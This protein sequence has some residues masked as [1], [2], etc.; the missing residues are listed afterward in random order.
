MRLIALTQ[1]YS[2]MVDDEDFDWLSQWKWH[3][4]VKK[5]TVYA[6]RN[7]RCEDGKCKTILMHREIL[8]LLDIKIHGE[9]ADGNGLNNTRGNIRPSTHSQNMMNRDSHANSSSVFKGVSW[10]KDR[11]KW[12]SSIKVNG[13]NKHLGFFENE[14]DAA[15]NYNHFAKKLHREYAR[16]NKV[17]PMFPDKEWKPPVLRMGNKSGFRGVSFNKDSGKWAASISN[18][19]VKKH[20]GYF[21]DPIDA[22]KAYD[23]AAKELHGENARL[24]FPNKNKIHSNANI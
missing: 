4:K 15:R 9:H 21:K 23:T 17:E 16:F 11:N 20:I 12:V 8:G 19:G 1:G 18:N 22:A 3:S 6:K 10:R 24:N 7:H 2:A 13:K 14:V 5:N